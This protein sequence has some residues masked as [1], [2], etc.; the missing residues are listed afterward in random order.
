MVRNTRKT[1]LHFT[2]IEVTGHR[3]DSNGSRGFN[4]VGL[5]ARDH[6]VLLAKAYDTFGNNDASS[7]MM[8]DL[9]GLRRGSIVIASVKDE[10]SRKLSAEVKNIFTK[11]GSKEISKLGFREGFAFIGVKGQR[12]GVEKR[13]GD[14]KSVV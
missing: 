2:T 5:D 13:G 14:R 9:K 4:I 10:G 12:N 7:D 6:T 8:K 11:W 1:C 3:M